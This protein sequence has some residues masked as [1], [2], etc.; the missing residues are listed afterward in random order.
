[1]RVPVPPVPRWVVPPIHQRCAVRVEQ[2]PVRYTV[3]I[4]VLAV[5]ADV[6][7][8]R[9]EGTQK[10]RWGVESG[11]SERAGELAGPES[12]GARRHVG[13]SLVMNRT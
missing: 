4:S 2:T 5:E 13:V 10:R 1:M 12:A 7:R 9:G 6:E 8:E 3:N 11:V